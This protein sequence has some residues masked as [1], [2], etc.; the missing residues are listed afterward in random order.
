MATHRPVLSLAA[1]LSLLGVFLFYLIIFCHNKG[2]P[3]VIP[4]TSRALA[5]KAALKKKKEEARKEAVASSKDGSRKETALRKRNR[6]DDTGID[7]EDMSQS[8]VRTGTGSGT[9]TQSEAET[10]SQV[11]LSGTEETKKTK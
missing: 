11:E 1:V 10:E 3:K 8:D 2:Q 6:R 7:S 9:G 5:K 4:K